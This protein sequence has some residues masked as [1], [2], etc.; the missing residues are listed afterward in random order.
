MVAD[1]AVVAVP[2]VGALHA[3]AQHLPLPLM[4]ARGT[5]VGEVVLLLGDAAAPLR[6]AASEM[7]T[8]VLGKRPRQSERRF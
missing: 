4:L 2:A 5:L 6:D 7:L 1:L 3:Y 8:T